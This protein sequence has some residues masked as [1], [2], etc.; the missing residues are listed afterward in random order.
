LR[1]LT[2]LAFGRHDAIVLLHSVFANALLLDGRL[3]D[4]LCAVPQP[5]AFCIGN[6]YKLMPEKMAFAERVGIALLVTQSGSADVQRLYRDRLGCD[7]VGIPNTGLDEHLFQPRVPRHERPVDLGYRADDS[8]WYLGH[9]ERREMAEHFVDVAPRFGLRVDISLAPTD[10]FT[11]SQWA[12]FLNRCQGQLGTEAGG[13]YFELD[14]RTRLA[15]NAYLKANPAA[16]FEAVHERYF[17]NYG[18]A[19]PIRIMSG[20]NVEAAGT[21]TVQLLFEGHYDGYLVPD[22]HYIPVRKDLSN[23]DEAIRKFRDVDFSAS[24]AERAYRLARETFTYPALLDR[25]ERALRTLV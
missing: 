14:D 21:K 23:V 22:V 2:L 17:A 6:E 3:L 13:D 24:V 12:D 9:R 10:R 1:A 16:T 15:V 19:T 25:Y 5:V 7:V 4:R 11:E 20:R 18:P 8:P